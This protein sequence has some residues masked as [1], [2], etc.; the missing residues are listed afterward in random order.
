VVA[1]GGVKFHSDQ[2]NPEQTQMIE[3]R[4]EQVR[5]TARWWNV[6]PHKLGD[7][8]RVA[9]NSLEQENNSYHDSTL[10]PRL[11]ALG[12]ECKCK[13]LRPEERASGRHFY[14]HD[15]SALLATDKATATSNSVAQFTNALITKNEGRKMIGLQP[16]EGGDEFMTPLN[17][18]V[19]SQPDDDEPPPD[20]ED[21]N[22]LEPDELRFVR[23]PLID[24]L[25]RALKSMD[26]TAGRKA[27]NLSTTKFADWLAH[28]LEAST[29]KPARVILDASV[30]AYAGAA[31]TTENELFDRLFA[32]LCAEIRNKAQKNVRISPQAAVLLIERIENA[33]CN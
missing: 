32:A 2:A 28:Q 23:M 18:T 4:K 33:E 11:T 22:D 14:L 31:K 12:D 24:S 3:A 17:M 6:P 13:L 19:G 10:S 30:G 1:R 9:H 27:K 16:V 21:E 8:T 26:A 7:D 20:E 15:V 25:Q 5:D 29:R